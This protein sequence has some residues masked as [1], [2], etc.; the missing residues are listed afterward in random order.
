MHFT[1]IFIRRP[2]FA[3]VLSLII[4]LIG[5][6][7]YFSLTVQLFPKM[8]AAVVHVS[9]TYPGADAELVE[10][11]I[12]TPVESALAGVD[13]IDYF[14][15]SSTQG[16][17]SI[18]I[19]FKMGYDI[20]TAVSDVNT[21]IIASRSK[22][23]SN[24][25]DPVIYKSDPSDRPTMHLNFSS[26]SMTMGQIT[27]YL[28]RVVQPQL[29]TLPGVAKAAV[30]GS[31][32]AMRIWLN[33]QLMAAHSV[34]AKDIK[35]ALLTQSLQVPSGQ[36]ETTSQVF[37]VKI[38]SELTTSEQFN[39]LV[40]KNKDG[41]L[42]RILD[43]GRAELGTASNDISVMFNG[44][45]SAEVPITPTS[46]AN[47]LEV[48]AAV[49]K[50][51]PKIKQNLPP[52]LSFSMPW[53]S[54]KFIAESIKEVKKTI[55]EATLCVILVVF[56][57]LGSWRSLLIPLV[58]IP[59]SLIGVCGVMLAMRYSLNVITLLAFVLAIGMVV[60]DAIVVAENIHRHMIAGKS[61]MEAALFGAREI[62]FAIISMTFTLAAVYAP[63]G[64][65]TGIVGSLFKEFA[66]TLA[67]A[68]II[69][70]FVALTLSPMMCS[71]IMVA[72]AK[73]GSFTS[74]VDNWSDKL[75]HF[76]RALLG[77]V[78]HRKIIVVLLIPVVLVISAIIYKFIPS[79]LAPTE[80]LGIFFIDA[81]APT[82]ATL[83]YTEKHTKLLEPIF[84]KI[85][86]K[87]NVLI[88]NGGEG[89]NSGFA[90]VILKPWGER[91]R[92]PSQ[93]ISTITPEI[94]A[95]AGIRAFPFTPNALPTG[96]DSQINLVLQT[97][98]SYQDLYKIMKELESAAYANPLIVN[99]RSSLKIDQSQLNVYVD[100][101]KSGDLDVSIK[102]IGDA[103]NLG[104]GKPTVGHFGVLGRSYGVIPQL[105]ES[106]RDRPEVL[107]NLYVSTASGSLVPLSQLITIE[108]VLQPQ[109][110]EHFQQLRAATLS[111]DLA[112]G[113]TLGQALD[114]LQDVAK[115][116]VPFDKGMQINYSGLSRQYFE[117]ENQM[118]IVFAFAILFIFLVLAAQF[119]SFRDPL[120]VLFSIPLSIFGA[121]LVLF[122]TNNTL[123]IYSQIGLITL[124]GL[125]SKHGIL[126]VEFANQL[127]I[128]G[129]SKREA[130]IEAASIR[131][132]PILMT[133]A[134]IVI[135]AVPL[136]FASGAS[137]I[138]RQQIGWVIIGGMLIGTLFT[139]FVVPTMYTYL[140]TR[141]TLKVHS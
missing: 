19:H 81:Q 43:I 114:Y 140:A 11:F 63:I 87:E 33:P 121:L 104:L 6:V 46:D 15:S 139:L 10:G 71:K 83:A 1:D 60:D 136:A 57:F 124:I 123:N 96:G 62:Q 101:N 23:P 18:T 2:V 72:H 20:N 34:T 58:T 70:G 79:D 48:A 64:F 103:I 119:E 126:I 91:I 115:K 3:T 130:I 44:R 110:L 8:N 127:Q 88:I 109:S 74:K 97:T 131:L 52:G 78:L 93:I 106:F 105:D 135:G 98:G 108:E 4:L 134:A 102:D 137:A 24:I 53:D 17:S 100:R 26:N 85:P 80:D 9:I 5:L 99:A 84:D 75:M 111:A 76:Y 55:I 59:L 68:V 29:Q 113:Y 82:S 117:A 94:N 22:L 13:G 133:T 120:I 47:P 141:K 30:W 116:I 129:R 50:I 138:S 37:N 31:P 86:E 61:R 65:L 25:W 27:D 107:N 45:T 125:I 12:T 67:S 40:I 118:A 35:T 112:P 66:F 28:S 73:P 132:R 90:I 92:K 36:I 16:E 56:L 128:Q 54:S 69:S 89:K 77:K 49:N 39:H 42:T 51:I 21:K 41:H 122:L 32:Y 38:F 7:S 14:T 95:I